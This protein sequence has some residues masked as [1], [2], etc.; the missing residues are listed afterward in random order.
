ML[1]MCTCVMTRHLNAH[2]RSACFC[3]AALS[4]FTQLFLSFLVCARRMY[5]VPNTTTWKQCLCL[6]SKESVVTSAS[7]CAWSR[8][9]C[10]KGVLSWAE[11]YQPH[12]AT[13]RCIHTR[14]GAE[15]SNALERVSTLNNI[16]FHWLSTK[17]SSSPRVFSRLLLLFSSMLSSHY[18]NA[19][20]NHKQQLRL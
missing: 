14:P 17:Y 20:N 16:R 18:Y 1:W 13:R 2:T 15:K 7:M 4:R 11:I 5:A 8:S 3:L 10:K 19:A 9:I 12:V 6:L